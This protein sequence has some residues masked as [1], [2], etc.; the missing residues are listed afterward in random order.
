VKFAACGVARGGE[1]VHH[2]HGRRDGVIVPSTPLPE[3]TRVE[4]QVEANTSPKQ[5]PGP[6]LGKGMITFIAPDFD[7]PLDD[8][9]EYME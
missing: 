9:K 1:Y 5:R 4:I 3:G 8:F 7:T 2:H 6:G